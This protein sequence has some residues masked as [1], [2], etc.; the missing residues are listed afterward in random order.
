M[1]LPTALPLLVILITSCV[2][3][4]IFSSV[5]LNFNCYFDNSRWTGSILAVT[6]N[7]NICF[8]FIIYFIFYFIY[9]NYF[10]HIATSNPAILPLGIIY[11]FEYECYNSSLSVWILADMVVLKS[12]FI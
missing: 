1:N 5:K 2:S 8:S 3:S 4:S 10:E 6:I 9:P 7:S 12:F 11:G